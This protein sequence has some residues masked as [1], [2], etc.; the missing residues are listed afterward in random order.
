[1]YVAGYAVRAPIASALQDRERTE[2]PVDEGVGIG[3]D[4]GG[5]AP[6]ALMRPVAVAPMRARP[7]LCDSSR[8]MQ[9]GAAQ[10]RR[11]ALDG[12]DGP[13]AQ[14][15]MAF[16]WYVRDRDHRG[17]APRI[18]RMETI[19]CVAATDSSWRAMMR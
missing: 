18:E 19:R 9:H 17:G 1:M 16:A 14:S 4:P 3:A 8:T 11:N 2:I 6:N 12:W 5:V 13:K 15:T 10:M 7:V